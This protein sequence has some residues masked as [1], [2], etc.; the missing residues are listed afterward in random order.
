MNIA[1]LKSAIDAEQAA[2]NAYAAKPTELNANKCGYASDARDAI[3]WHFSAELV[4]KTG[5]TPDEIRR[6]LG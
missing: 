2:W 6:I 4:R 5:F 3:R 1:A